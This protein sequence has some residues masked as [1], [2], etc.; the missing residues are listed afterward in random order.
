[1][2]RKHVTD[3]HQQGKVFKNMRRHQHDGGR[4]WIKDGQLHEAINDVN[5]RL[6]TKSASGVVVAQSDQDK[7]NV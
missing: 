3:L 6:I 7:T 2:F 4:A 1:M 5:P